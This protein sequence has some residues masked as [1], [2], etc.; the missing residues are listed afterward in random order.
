[1]DGHRV[2]QRIDN[3]HPVLGADYPLLP[4]DLLVRDGVTWTKEAPGLCVYGFVL[5]DEQVA[6]LEPV[7]FERHGLAY[8]LLNGGSVA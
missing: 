7:Q 1:M 8:S 6:T 5:T 2:T 3:A 4:G